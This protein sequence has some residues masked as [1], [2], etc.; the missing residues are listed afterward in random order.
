VTT[1]QFKAVQLLQLGEADNPTIRL[2]D[3]T[4]TITADRDGDQILITTPVPSTSSLSSQLQKPKAVQIAPKIVRKKPRYRNTNVPKG[5]AHSKAKLTEQDVREMRS[6]FGDSEYR[7]GFG[8][9]YGIC[10]EIGK[11]YG[12]HV[13]TVYK[14]VH[15]QSWRH[16]KDA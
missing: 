2:E 11:V 9:I 14:I 16:V 3:G 1:F 15:G 12:V 5:E 8:S 13:T 7:K 10:E 4:L 6:L